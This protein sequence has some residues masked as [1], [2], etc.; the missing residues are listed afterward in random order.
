[1]QGVHLANK[2]TQP[3]RVRLDM[4]MHQLLLGMRVNGLA[5]KRGFENRQPYARNADNLNSHEAQHVVVRRVTVGGV[6]EWPMR[7]KN[8]PTKL[9]F[10]NNQSCAL[11]QTLLPTIGL[12]ARAEKLGEIRISPG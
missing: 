12:G 10:E 9:R 7:V 3:V 1:M 4:D 2:L 6:K 5:R 8:S 11:E